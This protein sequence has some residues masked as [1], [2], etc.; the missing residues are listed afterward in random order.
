MNVKTP[1]KHY[2]S[3]KL[4]P[5]L[6]APLLIACGADDPLAPDI[7]PGCNPLAA[8]SDCNFPFPSTF[9][10]KPDSD[11]T[12]GFRV[13]LDP[14]LLPKRDTVLPLDVTPYNQADGF[15]PIVPI[16]VHFGV[17]ID[18][19][20]LPDQ[21]ELEQ[22]LQDGSTVALF[23]METGQR[24]MFFAEMD[25]NRNSEIND[26]YAFF[27]RP[28][29][30]MQM[31]ARHAVII[32]NNLRDKNGNALE[33][34]RVFK[35][36]RDQEARV[37]PAIEEMK[38][39]YE[40]IFSFAE[41]H[42]YKRES[43]L[44]A[45][46]FPVASEDY[47]LGSV[48]SMREKTMEAVKNNELGYK[49]TKVSTDPN[50]YVTKI[51]E[52]D[53]EVPT[54]LKADDTFEFDEKHHPIRQPAN[55]SYPFTMLI[56][57][58]AKL[59]QPLPLIVIGH[60]IFGNGRSFLTSDGDGKAIQQLMEQFGFV[61]V[62][63]DWIGLSTNDLLRI[64]G[65]LSADL[66]RIGIITDQLQQAL[67]NAL[68]LTKLS[69]GKISEDPQIK[70]GQNALIDTSQIYYWGASLGGIEGS[71]FIS[72]S[73]DIARAAFGVPGCSW[74][75]MFT[76]SIVFPPVRSLLEPHYGD[77][78]AFSIAFSV[79]QTR[80]DHSDPVNVTQ[81]MFKK[82]L[83][84][85]PPNRMIVLQEAIGDSQVP[86]MTTEV[87]ARGMGVKL[88]TPSVTPVFGLEEVTS[89]ANASVLAQYRLPNFDQPAPPLNNTPPA[90]DNGVHYEMNFLSNV[91][92][93]IADLFLKSEVVQHCDK[94]CDPD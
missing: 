27:I 22:S 47:I 39:H 69:K 50:Q 68:V 80:F 9:H 45:W 93:Q 90:D 82:P 53:F 30:P 18:T 73:D 84:D 74:A 28:Q 62:A 81:L 36:L 17:D 67:I 92:A 77:P 66:N 83:P 25:Q 58:K 41:Q 70:V 5:F 20:P 65:E 85:A 63:T 24:V 61:A 57:Q 71:S 1:A 89:P 91:H 34:P 46:D 86:N 35:A 6:F 31:G 32:T 15:S 4:L 12:T 55:R 33:P 94:E 40:E 54:F 38:P 23:N 78:M 21:F 56:P 79:F 11:T 29:E 19:D 44:M 10:V 7:T 42:G 72:I 48:L 49:I 64:A 16:I 8:S 37:S 51:I 60:G 59:G 26:R 2:K 3:R 87:L 75:T 14:E 88:M 43:L 52:G 76:R 13:N